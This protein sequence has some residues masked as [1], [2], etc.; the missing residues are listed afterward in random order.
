MQV[1]RE[2]TKY[3]CKLEVGQLKSPINTE[4]IDEYYKEMRFSSGKT[5]VRDITYMTSNHRS[6]R[7]TN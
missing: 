1:T 7:Y 6:G 3:N 2:Q 4:Q 5:S